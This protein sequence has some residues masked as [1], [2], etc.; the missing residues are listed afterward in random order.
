MRI[1]VAGAWVEKA[2]RAEVAMKRLREEGFTISH[3]WTVDE[4][5]ADAARVDGKPVG[6]SALPYEERVKRAKD[7]LEGVESADVIWLLAPVN[8]GASGAWTEFGYALAIR[9]THQMLK[10]KLGFNGTP[11]PVVISG[12]TYDRTIFA[13][14][15][16][17]Q[18]HDDEDAFRHIKNLRISWEV[19]KVRQHEIKSGARLPPLVDTHRQ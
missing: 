6:D 5:A 11:V 7:D 13:T 3:D 19:E 4:L 15:A 10:E 9:N 2:E 1:Y 17:F 16:D 12:P 14:Q 8:R 18:S